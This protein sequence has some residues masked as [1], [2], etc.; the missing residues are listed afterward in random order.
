MRILCRVG[1][2]HDGGST[3]R[4]AQV[5][6]PIVG[7][8]D[9]FILNTYLRSICNVIGVGKS[10]KSQRQKGFAVS[11]TNCKTFAITVARVLEGATPYQDGSTDTLYTLF[12]VSEK[13]DILAVRAL[14][15]QA[16][17]LMDELDMFIA[18]LRNQG[19]VIEGLAKD[20]M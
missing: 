15:N 2:I 20:M 19:E 16:V 1:S 9:V 5:E 10:A 17:A 6:Q 12:G 4:L 3:V 11:T 7:V 13:F 14:R 8:D 18:G